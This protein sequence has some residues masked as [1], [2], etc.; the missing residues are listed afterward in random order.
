MSEITPSLLI[1][2]MIEHSTL[3]AQMMGRD[4]KRLRKWFEKISRSKRKP[5]ILFSQVA[6]DDVWQRPQEMA[7][8]LSKYR[9]VLY[10]SPVQIHQTAGPLLS[11]WR[12]LRMENKGKLIIYCPQILS[13]EYKSGMIRRI[14]RDILTRSLWSMNN[15]KSFLFLSNSPFSGAWINRFPKAIV[16]YD[17][18]DDFCAFEWAPGEGR[19]W[20]DQLIQESQ[21][22][23]T[24][25]WSMQEKFGSRL[26]GCE[27]LA[28]GVDFEKFQTPKT[29]P[30]DIKQLP[31]K[32][33]LYV[34]TL[35]DR[36]S[37]QLIKETAEN[38]PNHSFIFVG[39]KRQTFE[40]LN[41]PANVHFLGL[42]PHDDLPAYYQH[43][44]FGIMPFADNEAA[45][46]IN[47]VKSLEYLSSGLPVL[48]T[49]IPDV[50]RFYRPHIQIEEPINWSAAVSKLIEEDN[51][52]GSE[53]RKEFARNKSWKS[54]C[55]KM[56]KKLRKFDA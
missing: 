13:G 41:Y 11:R 23:F 55:E 9:P 4:E 36:V 10:I 44:D 3:L 6:W 43:C 34:G 53:A 18:I 46:A 7:R 42:K 21:F 2:W 22:G 15:L 30:E 49:P 31:G 25:T 56:E 52:I 50:E 29:I 8:G 28:S 45:R 40:N 24:G 39:P 51:T 1:R 12:P 17:V 16:G 35:N 37:G 33:I 5:L 47:P 32:K 48:S 54:M 20:E 14:N 38:F 26:P 27:F 19:N